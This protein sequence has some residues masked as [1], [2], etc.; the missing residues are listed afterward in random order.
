MFV[1]HGNY[2]DNSVCYIYGFIANFVQI[3]RIIYKK[4]EILISL[5]IIS[6]G[7]FIILNK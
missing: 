4:L 6:F 1:K 5:I 7:I 3:Y 2:L